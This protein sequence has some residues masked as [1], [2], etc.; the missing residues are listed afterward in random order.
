MLIKVEEVMEE[1]EQTKCQ[2][3]HKVHVL[4]LVSGWNLLNDLRVERV[5]RLEEVGNV[6]EFVVRRL[7]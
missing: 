2:Q 4:L 5:K 6:G 1:R 3:L 7:L